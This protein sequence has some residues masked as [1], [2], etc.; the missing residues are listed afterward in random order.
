MSL[1]QATVVLTRPE[2]KNESLQ[3]QFEDAGLAVVVVP[4]LTLR[5]K[6]FSEPVPSLAAYDLIFFVSGYAADCFFD[7]L[8][9]QNVRWPAQLQAGCVG[10]GTAKTLQARGVPERDILSPAAG[11]PRDAGGLV[12]TLKDKGVFASLQSVLIVC[13][14]T[15]SGWFAEQLQAA[16]VA[17]TRLPLYTRQ[18]RPWSEQEQRQMAFLLREAGAGPLYVVLTSP[19]GVQS[20]VRNAADA[21]WCPAQAARAITFVITHPGQQERLI[22]GWQHTFSGCDPAALRIVQA[23]PED[24]AIF[25]AV[26]KSD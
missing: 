9:E 16:S 12:A 25:Q 24:A 26:T 19:Q 2:G 14:T 11:Q 23:S 7:L 15:G 13:G 18:A 8:D 17:V 5:R 22:E 3:R 21:G 20:F 6:P 1:S 10:P 4:A